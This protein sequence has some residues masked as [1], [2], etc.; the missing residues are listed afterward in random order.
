MNIHPQMEISCEM[1]ILHGVKEKSMLVVLKQDEW[2]DME[3]WHGQIKE[4]I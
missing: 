2:K 3:N 1:D 4:A